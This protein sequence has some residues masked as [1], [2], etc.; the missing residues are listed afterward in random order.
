M[1]PVKF[2]DYLKDGHYDR[3]LESMLPKVFRDVSKGV[4][5]ASDDYKTRSGY[6]IKEANVGEVIGQMFGFASSDMSDIIQI[7][8]IGNLPSVYIEN[9]LIQHPICIINGF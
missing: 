9:N 2:I 5:Y 4:K 8:T 6:D 7:S 3:A 1:S